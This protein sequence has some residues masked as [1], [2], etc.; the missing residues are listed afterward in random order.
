MS[1][2]GGGPFRVEAVDPVGFGVQVGLLAAGEDDLGAVL[3]QDLGDR[4][5][6]AP[7]GAGDKRDPPGQVETGGCGHD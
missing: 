3:G 5:A 1:G 4:A 7:A 2:D 6:D